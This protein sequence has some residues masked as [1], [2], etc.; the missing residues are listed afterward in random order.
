MR[1]AKSVADIGCGR[2]L[3]ERYLSRSQTYLPVDLAARDS[4]T[5]VIDLNAP[6]DLARLPVAD[7]AALIGVLEYCYAP[8]VLL[9]ALRARYRQVVLT[10]NVHTDAAS[11]IEPRLA[12]GWINHFTADDLNALVRR[13]GFR[14]ITQKRL[15]ARR[16]ERL[17]DLRV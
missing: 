7:A 1:K 15:D 13:A 16:D 5:I 10:F 14:L 8:D 6:A 12:N 4:R 17:L 2:M 11:P 9:A 3:L